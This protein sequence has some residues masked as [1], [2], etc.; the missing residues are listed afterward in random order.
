MS[1]VSLTFS[2]TGMY[3]LFMVSILFNA[4]LY[5]LIKYTISDENQLILFNLTFTYMKYYYYWKL[6]CIIAFDGY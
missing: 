5:Y 6:L 2:I 4:S 3:S 1:N